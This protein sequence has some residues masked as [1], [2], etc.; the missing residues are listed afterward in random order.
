LVPFDAGSHAPDFLVVRHEP[1]A[2][3]VLV[4]IT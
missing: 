4:T 1:E 2:G 3:S